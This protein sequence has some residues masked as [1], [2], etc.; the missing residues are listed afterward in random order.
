MK[1][2]F[3]PFAAAFMLLTSATIVVNATDYSVKDGTT[4]AF[5]SKDPS[6]TFKANG[7]VKFDENDLAGS[8][9]DLSFPV[10]SISTGNNM[11]NKKAQTE[12]WFEASKYPNVTFVSTVIAKSGSDYMVTGNL[13]MKGTSKLKKVPMKVTKSGSDLV[14]SGTFSVNRMEFSVGK[15]S[16]VVPDVMTINYSIPVTKK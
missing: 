7:T 13:K 5:K 1:K 3:F 10:S 12:E 6:G 9:I 4:V 14:L 15:K 8:K 2:L 16:D 11:K